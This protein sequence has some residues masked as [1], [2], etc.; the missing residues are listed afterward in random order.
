MKRGH[1]SSDAE[2]IDDYI[3][4]LPTIRTASHIGRALL[5]DS[6]VRCVRAACAAHRAVTGGCIERSDFVE[7][8]M[9]LPIRKLR[10]ECK[11]HGIETVG[12]CE[13]RE[14]LDALREDA[15]RTDF[16]ATCSICM[17]EYVHGE[18]VCVFLCNHEFHVECA[19]QAVRTQFEET[20]EMPTCPLCRTPVKWTPALAAQRG[21]DPVSAEVE[22]R[23]VRP[24]A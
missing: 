24:R 23:R 10:Q 2:R 15:S 18:D 9:R 19:L 20:A 11:A 1:F 5:T 16:S 13:R 7:A 4:R 14:F 17:D 6:P 8:L 12:F 3:H 22:G 21:E